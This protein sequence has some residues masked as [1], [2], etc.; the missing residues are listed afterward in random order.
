MQTEYTGWI[1][2]FSRNSINIQIGCIGCQ[3]CIRIRIGIYLLKYRMLY[4]HIL[5][6][7]FNYQ[8]CVS[9]ISP[10]RRKCEAFKY[11]L[12]LISGQ[13]TTCYT[14]II[15]IADFLDAIL[16]SG[17]ILIQHQYGIASR[18]TG[19]RN[20]RTHSACTNDCDGFKILR[21][22]FFSTKCFK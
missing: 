9:N 19:H 6:Y 4:L 8:I 7:R 17:F 16:K 11:R 10:L 2:S 18:Q 20:S 22:R 5:K 1:F 21:L 14:S 13:L 3:Q 12:C 15:K